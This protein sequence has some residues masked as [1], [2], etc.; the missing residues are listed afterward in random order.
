M[1]KIIKRTFLLMLLFVILLSGMIG[2]AYFIE[3][4]LLRE[5]VSRSKQKKKSVPVKSYF[6]RIH[7]LENITVKPISRIL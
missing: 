3:P 5:N 1:R 4:N 2:Y 6:L 7:I